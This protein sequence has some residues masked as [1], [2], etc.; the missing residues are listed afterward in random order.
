M[1]NDFTKKKKFILLLGCLTIWMK[2]ETQKM[3]EK[4]VCVCDR[5]KNKQTYK[6]V[7]MTSFYGQDKNI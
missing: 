6:S 2:Y 3:N 7:N 4:C 1:K 5:E